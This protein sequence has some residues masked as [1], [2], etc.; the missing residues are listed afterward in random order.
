MDDWTPAEI[1]EAALE[2]W[3]GGGWE[4]VVAL[5]ATVVLVAW[6]RAFANRKG[7]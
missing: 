3:R 1:A 2:L 7:Q 6:A 4:L 5:L